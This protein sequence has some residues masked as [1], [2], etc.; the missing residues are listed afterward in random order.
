MADAFRIELRGVNSVLSKLDQTQREIIEELDA[1]LDATAEEVATAA[2]SDVPKD[3]G[4]LAMSISVNR[5]TVLTKSIVATKGYAPFIEFGTGPFAAE[6]LA[7]QPEELQ[8][9]AQQFYING[10]GRLP[11]HPFIW[12]NLMAAKGRLKTR[13]EN[14]MKRYR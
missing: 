3:M 10:K 2:K 5:D 11:A 6:Y 12:P 14:V 8:R 13:I 4:P 7:T 1:E 9:Y